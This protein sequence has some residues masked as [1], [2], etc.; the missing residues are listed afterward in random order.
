MKPSN[1]TKP[2]LV[3]PDLKYLTMS[4]EQLKSIYWSWY[5]GGS[6]PIGAMRTICS[7]IEAVAKFRG[8]DVNKWT[9]S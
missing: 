9:R 7:L 6:G 4:E 3:D 5:P 1:S 2:T 8:F